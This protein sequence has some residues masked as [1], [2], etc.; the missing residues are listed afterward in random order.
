MCRSRTANHPVGSR[1]GPWSVRLGRSSATSVMQIQE[2]VFSGLVAVVA[3]KFFC[4]PSTALLRSVLLWHVHGAWTESFVAGRHNYLLPV[5][6]S[7]DAE[8]RGLSGRSW[9]S[10][11]EVPADRLADEEVDLVVLQRPQELEL[12]ARWLGRRPG[13]DVPAVYVEHNAPRPSPAESRHPVADRSD[14]TLVHVT[15]FNR[16]MWDNG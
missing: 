8:G 12:T 4:M 1:A 2:G 14:I 7:R 15:D 5:N 3:G 13:I 9:A 16:L 11:R 6:Q 10:A